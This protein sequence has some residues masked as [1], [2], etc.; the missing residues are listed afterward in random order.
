[1]SEELTNAPMTAEEAAAD[2]ESFDNE[3]VPDISASLAKKDVPATVPTRQAT[4][5]EAPPKVE[6]AGEDGAEG[7]AEP[8]ED[9]KTETW[10]DAQGRVH[11]SK[12]G[13]ILPKGK[14]EA[15]AATKEVEQTPESNFTKKQKEIERQKSVLSGFEEEKKRVRAEQDARDAALRDRERQLELKT[16][17]Q[18]LKKGERRRDANGQ[19]IYSS[20]EYRDAAK[21]YRNRALK[22]EEDPS[23]VGYDVLMARAEQAAVDAEKREAQERQQFFENR[24]TQLALEVLNSEG[25][26]ELKDINSPMAKQ[27][28]GVFADEIERAQKHGRPSIFA[29]I[30][31][32]FELAVEVAKLQR[33]AASSEEW[34]A[35]YEA[36]HKEVE[37]LNELTSLESSTPTQERVT[38]R[39][40]DMTAE[41]GEAE[42]DREFEAAGGKLFTR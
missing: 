29:M 27:V 21:D 8:K 41:E 37:R 16:Q 34:K 19:P 7:D 33:Q 42:L 23:G 1:M 15:P 12:T 39:F 13:R 28:Q 9:V 4:K 38:K 31:D 14:E 18:N 35:K 40:E 26:E 2:L 5:G 6:D 36:E 22:G 20:E 25:N 3:P 30:P 10:T 11:D 17:E 32:G 24:K